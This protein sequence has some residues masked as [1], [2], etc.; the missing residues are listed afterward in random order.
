MSFV[1]CASHSSVCTLRRIIRHRIGLSMSLLVKRS[2]K[3]E[4]EIKDAH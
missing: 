3:S 4:S 1:V 2:R